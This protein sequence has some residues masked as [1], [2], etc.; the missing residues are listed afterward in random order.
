LLLTST[1]TVGYANVGGA[2]ATD[3][4]VVPARLQ[5]WQALIEHAVVVDQLCRR[6]R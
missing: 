5:K 4:Q 6:D 3:D 1:L 2:S